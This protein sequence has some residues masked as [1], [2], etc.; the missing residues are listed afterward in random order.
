M[1]TQI[2]GRG[3]SAE[4]LREPGNRMMLVERFQRLVGINADITIAFNQD[5]ELLGTSAVSADLS[6][7]TGGG[8]NLATHGGATDSA[9]LAPHLDTNQTS[10]TT[11]LWA[12]SKSVEWGC[13]IQ[14]NSALTNTTLW[15][16]LKLTNTP[17]QAT[18]NDQVFFKYANGTHT[19]WQ[20]MSSIAG[21]DTTTDTGVTLA[22]STQYRLWITINSD[23]KATFWIDGIPYYTTAALTSANLIPYI[24]V[25]SAT[26]A[27]AKTLVVRNCWISRLF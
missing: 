7:N 24:G 17:T 15:A 8:L 10:W 6:A 9:I 3:P 4:N 14:T 23:R 16:G 19:T 26:D 25:L 22:V 1:S 2:D 13:T 20:A 21:T 12:T 11:T 27:T 5:F 18:D